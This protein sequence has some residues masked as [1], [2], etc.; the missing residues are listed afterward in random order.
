[1]SDQFWVAVGLLFIFEGMLPFM[2]PSGWRRLFEQ[3]LTMTDQQLRIMGLVSLLIGCALIWWI[4][5]G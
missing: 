3:M 4:I 5:P 1:M 2:S